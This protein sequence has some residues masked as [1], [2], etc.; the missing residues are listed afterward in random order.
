MPTLAGWLTGEQVSQELI[1]QTL[2]TMGE[3][4]GKHGGQLA[5]TV[6]PGAGLISFVDTA[7]TMRQNTEPP[8]LD[9]VP[10]RRTMVYHRP[11]SGNHI[12]YYVRDWPAEGSLLFASE[13]KALLA[14]GV[15]RRLSL[16]AL[17]AHTRLLFGRYLEYRVTEKVPVQAQF[18]GQR[19][20]RAL[21]GR[22]EHL[23][24]HGGHAPGSTTA[25]TDSVLLV[26]RDLR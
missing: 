4:L 1:E 17:D 14:V 12:L 13:I 23:P 6:Q 21:G 11:L 20:P 19:A 18:R 26:Y 24:Q 2:R 9:W 10:A 22:F 5:I 15:P 8:L 7:Y 16:P 3:V 25:V